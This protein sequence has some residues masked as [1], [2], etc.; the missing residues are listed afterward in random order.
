MYW[1]AKPLG[2][3]TS[4]Q[5]NSWCWSHIQCNEYA[6]AHLIMSSILHPY[7]FW[8]LNLCSFFLSSLSCTVQSGD[9]TLLKVGLFIYKSRHTFELNPLGFFIIQ[10]GLWCMCFPR[11]Y[12]AQLPCLEADN[13]SFCRPLTAMTSVNALSW[14][15]EFTASGRLWTIRL[16]RQ[17]F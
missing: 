1:L 5:S 3:H 16:S 11:V 15:K 7:S 17:T 8:S 10:D 6:W 2:Q 14:S 4:I 9:K 12:Q 13:L